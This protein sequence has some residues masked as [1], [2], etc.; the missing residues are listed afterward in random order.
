MPNPKPELPSPDNVSDAE[1]ARL[2][3]LEDLSHKRRWTPEEAAEVAAIENKVLMGLM[4]LRNHR[5]DTVH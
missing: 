1:W 2:K 4:V 3:L 5:R